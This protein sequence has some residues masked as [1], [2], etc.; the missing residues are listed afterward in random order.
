MGV[1]NGNCM[2][3]VDDN[4]DF[5]C[6]V[7]CK[8]S[9]KLCKKS[10][11]CIPSSGLSSSKKGNTK[12]AK[13]SKTSKKGGSKLYHMK[14]TRKSYKPSLNWIK[15][16]EDADVRAKVVDIYNVYK[17]TPLRLCYEKEN[18]FSI[19]FD[20][21]EGFDYVELF[22][23]P[24]KKLHPYSASVFVVCKKHT[25]VPDYL[26][27]ALKYASETINIEQLMTESV[28]NNHYAKT[29]EKKAVLVTGSC[30]SLTI[31]AITIQFIIDM[32][33]QT[34]K[35][36]FYKKGYKQICKEFRDE[37]DRRVGLYLCGKGIQP[38]IQWFKNRV[39]HEYIL[40]PWDK[41]TQEKQGCPTRFSGSILAN[42][43]STL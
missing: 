27:G 37:Y 23:T 2:C 4:N 18:L 5:R 14:Q 16:I 1:D 29:G 38:P 31:S 13:V 33:K 12:T 15:E 8:N 20:K 25:Y 39:E 41:K 6:S 11:D 9:G 21:I 17:K 40:G 22:T 43:A 7:S 24:M 35:H 34:P 19:V 36:Q 28:Y 26:L 32:V 30:A 3:D 10:S 42:K